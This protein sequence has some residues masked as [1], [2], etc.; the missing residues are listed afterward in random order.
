[1]CF[2]YFLTTVNVHN[3][4]KIQIEIRLLQIKTIDNYICKTISENKKRK[5]N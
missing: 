3:T 5:T 1:M 4:F 2:N